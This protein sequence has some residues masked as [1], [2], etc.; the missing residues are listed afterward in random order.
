MRRT[1]E[2][3]TKARLNLSVGPHAPVNMVD[4]V[5]EV[6][7]N[8][9]NGILGNVC[10]AVLRYISYAKFSHFGTSIASLDPETVQ[11]PTCLQER[12]ARQR[13]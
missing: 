6:E 4:N 3:G 1:Y 2:R 13:S 9:G 5:E 8:A 7:K 12:V 10:C 11:L